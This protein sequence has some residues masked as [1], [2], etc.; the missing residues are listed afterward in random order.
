P[1]A[2]PEWGRVG[3]LAGR[4]TD[5][6]PPRPPPGRGAAETR[7]ASRLALRRVHHQHR[8]R[9]DPVA[10]RPAPHPGPHRRQDE[11]AQSLRRGEPALDRLAPQQR[12]AAARRPSLHPERLAASPRLRRRPGQSRT[13]SAALPTPRRPR[14]TRRPRPP[15]NPAHPTRLA[16]GARP[17]QRLGTAPSPPP[18]LTTK[19]PHPPADRSK[20]DRGTGAHPSIRAGPLRLNPPH[21]ARR[22]L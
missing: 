13:E 1:P 19:P 10:R 17:R 11:R 9:A 3:G 18:R 2:R 5:H 15:P 20:P 16:M 7:R 22:T 8:H 12:L 6:R 14:P 4:P 21:L